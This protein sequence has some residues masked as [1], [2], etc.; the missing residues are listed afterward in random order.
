MDGFDTS[1]LTY[2]KTGTG[3]TH[4]MI[5][6]DEIRKFL[7]EKDELLPISIEKYSGII[8]RICVDIV[9]QKNCL[10]SFGNECCLKVTYLENY[11]NSINC[12]ISGKQ[13]IFKGWGLNDSVRF[14]DGLEPKVI[15]CS[16]VYD[17]MSVIC[18]GQKNIKVC[19]TKENP[20]SSRS[21]TF[22]ILSLEV[23]YLDGTRT[24]AKMILVDM[25]GSERV[26]FF[27][28]FLNILF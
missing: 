15:I 26:F 6:N 2:G 11:L 5:G 16:S 4:T 9:N 7:H 10:I 24:S 22:L 23:C 21:H 17:I 8:P 14:K 20:D 28:L 12:L 13:N 18:K 1:I 25:A 19:Q 3:K 27:Y